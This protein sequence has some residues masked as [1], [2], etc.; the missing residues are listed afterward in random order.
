[1]RRVRVANL[2][3][4]RPTANEALLRLDFELAQARREGA[5]A[6]KVIHGY[7]SS[8]AGGVLRE[9]VQA[10]LRRMVAEQKVRS[11][12]P[13]EEWRISNQAAWDM[14]QSVPELKH[15]RDLGRVNRGISMVLL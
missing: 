7:G 15:D 12:V 6:L 5:A 10:A 1:M 2:E 8:G 9:V 14:Q 4:G 13:G 11:F 3:R